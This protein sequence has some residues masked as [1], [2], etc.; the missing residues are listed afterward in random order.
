[1]LVCHC[2]ELGAARED[3]MVADR[4]VFLLAEQETDYIRPVLIAPRPP[5]QHP[6]EVAIAGPGDPPLDTIATGVFPCHQAAVRQIALRPSRA[7][8][9]ERFTINRK[10]F[11]CCSVHSSERITGTLVMLSWRVVFKRD[12]RRP[13]RRRSRPA[14]ESGIL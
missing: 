13:C 1:V 10:G 3:D 5:H 6:S 2:A 7:Q 12:D 4:Q 9:T 14:L 8:V 11:T